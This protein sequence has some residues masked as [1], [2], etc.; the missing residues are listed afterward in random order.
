[1]IMEISFLSKNSRGVLKFLERKSFIMCKIDS[2][3]QVATL[4]NAKS[5]VLLLIIWERPVKRIR[6]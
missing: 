2:N 5:V 3:V 1:M 4:N 6:R